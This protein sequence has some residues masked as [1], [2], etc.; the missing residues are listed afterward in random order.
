MD[1]CCTVKSSDEEIHKQF[2]FVSRQVLSEIIDLRLCLQ[3]LEV[4]GGT[5]FYM[6]AADYG[7]KEAWIGALG[8][9]MIKPSVMIEDNFDNEYM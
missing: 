7:E 5:I 3:K 1:T 4:Q 2:S 6:Y 9:A 8:K